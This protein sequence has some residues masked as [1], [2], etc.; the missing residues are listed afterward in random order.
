MISVAL[1]ELKRILK[2]IRTIIIILIFVLFSYGMSSTL[3]N[4][5]GSSGDDITAAYSSIRLLVF[6][7]GYL[8]VS[9][10]SNN[11][12]NTEIE[13]G[14]IKFVLAKINRPQFIVGKFIGIFLFWFICISTSV[15]VIL[16][17]TNQVDLSIFFMLICVVT[18]YISLCI[19]LSVLVSRSSMTNFIGLIIG[20]MF[21]ITGLW[22]TLSDKWYSSFKYLFPYEYILKGGYLIVVPVLISIIYL[23]IAVFSFSRKEV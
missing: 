22:V 10:L 8:F 20:I 7:L 2:S 12:I 18:Y 21:P 5:A 9:I 16:F 14:S 17:L 3:S 1:E 6:I 15:T 4:V 11:C 19:L 23:S 13:T